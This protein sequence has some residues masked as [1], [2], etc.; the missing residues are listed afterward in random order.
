M[1]MGS[2]L[3]HYEYI[4]ASITAEEAPETLRRHQILSVVQTFC[5]GHVR[6]VVYDLL[7]I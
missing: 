7:S 6:L 1:D 3:G 5:S 2:S 4:K